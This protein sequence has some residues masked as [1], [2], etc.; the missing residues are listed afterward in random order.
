M[1]IETDLGHDPD[2]YFAI[3]YLVAAGIKIDALVITPGDKDQLAIGKFLRDELCL[4]FPIGFSKISD[5]LSSGSIHRDLLKK[6]DRDCTFKGDG[7]GED[8]IEEV[9]RPD[10][11]MFVIGP[12][13]S[14]G[15]YFMDPQSRVKA[16]ANRDIAKLT[17]QGGFLSYKLHPYATI[18]VPHMINK[19]WM[20][21]FNMNG[22]RTGTVNICNA[23]ICERRFCGKNVCH[24]VI[25]KSDLIDNM[26]KPQTRAAEL[27]ME[28]LRFLVGDKKFHDPVAAVCHLHPEIGNWV[29]GK[30]TKMEG[31]W[32]TILDD[33]GDYILAGLDYD[34]FW[35]H[36][37]NW[38]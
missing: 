24:T 35:D 11:E 19:M 5:K 38:S 23:N 22:S 10:S 6:Y 9:A 8:I 33:N 29:R 17:M 13:V 31:G 12:P 26:A 36:I 32:G 20:P 1:I 4:D 16:L 37:H 21:T 18:L 15:K 27:F 3:C 34:K 14:T 2:D 25:A 7:F 30:P 28:G